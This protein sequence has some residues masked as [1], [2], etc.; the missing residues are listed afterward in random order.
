MIMGARKTEVRQ[1]KLNEFLRSF[2]VCGDRSDETFGTFYNF[3]AVEESANIAYTKQEYLNTFLIA[4]SIQ[5][6]SI[7]QI[8]GDI[9]KKPDIIVF[10]LLLLLLLIIV[11]QYMHDLVLI[12][13]LS[14]LFQYSIR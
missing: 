14:R 9:N 12:G 4:S 5:V 8:I 13:I 10:I 6:G 1:I 11:V 2:D 3:N 7:I